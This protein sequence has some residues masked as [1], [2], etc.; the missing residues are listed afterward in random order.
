MV[1]P[2]LFLKTSRAT[3]SWQ[4]YVFFQLHYYILHMLLHFTETF[5]CLSYT[6]PLNLQGKLCVSAHNALL[7]S[8]KFHSSYGGKGRVRS[9][10]KQIKLLLQ[11]QEKMKIGSQLITFCFLL[12][13]TTVSGMSCPPSWWVFSEETHVCIATSEFLLDYKKEHM[14]YNLKIVR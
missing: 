13:K 6:I 3:P 2:C 8:G 5:S 14:N 10:K 4:P 7:Y 12:F 9:S 11:K 1:A